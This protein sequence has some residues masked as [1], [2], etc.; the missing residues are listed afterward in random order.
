[1]K[2]KKFIKGLF[3]LPIENKITKGISGSLLWGS[4]GGIICICI[5]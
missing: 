5:R 1:M 3:L 2:H 4:V